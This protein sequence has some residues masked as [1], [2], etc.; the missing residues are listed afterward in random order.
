MTKYILKRIVEMVPVLIG[1]TIFSFLIIQLVPGDPIRILLGPRATA[2]NLAELRNSLGLDRPLLE[3]YWAFIK[4]IFTFN[5]GASITYR[6]PVRDIISPRVMP[7]LFLITYGLAFAILIAVPLAIVSALRH[8]RLADSVVRLGSTVTFAMPSFWLGLVLSLIFGLKL[9]WFPTSGY[10]NAALGH[11]ESLTL[12]ALTV[13]L[14]LSPV[15]MRILRSSLIDTLSEEFVEATR[16]RGISEHRVFGKHVIRNSM[17]S[18]I[19][20]LGLFAGVLLSGTVVVE[21]VFAIPGLGSLLVVAVSQRDYPVIQALTFLF[22]FAVVMV[23]LMTDLL[24]GV[25]DPR[26][27]L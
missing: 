8:N 15:I 20:V 4:G 11:F 2:A 19:T 21:N 6:I 1:I 17:T 26:V 12:P 25:L 9:G 10:G 24:Y 22:G 18:T 5:Y 3:Q 16:S 7:S 23:S 27:R 13:G 14:Y